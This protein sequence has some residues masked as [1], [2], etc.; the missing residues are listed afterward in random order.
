MFGIDAK[1]HVVEQGEEPG[2]IFLRNTKHIGD[3]VHRK[4]I[5]DFLYELDVLA[6]DGFVD[7]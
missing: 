4:L 3:H 2:A 7:D 5:G 1:Q 6:F